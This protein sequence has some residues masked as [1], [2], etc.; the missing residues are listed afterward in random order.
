MD[1]QRR[2][3]LSRRLWSEPRSNADKRQKVLDWLEWAFA[4]VP[5]TLESMAELRASILLDRP[6]LLPGYIEVCQDD[7][8]VWETLSGLVRLYRG[9]ARERGE[10]LMLPPPLAKWGLDVASGSLVMPS[11]PARPRLNEYRD[12]HMAISVEKLHDLGCPYAP[13]SDNSACHL[14]AK[15][16]GMSLGRVR[17]IWFDQRKQVLAL[18]ATSAGDDLFSIEYGVPRPRPR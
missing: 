7:R 8:G 3:K 2:A 15:R 13:P 12:L 5:C 4:D 9:R 1:S 10:P 16:L 17:Q 6:D 11:W 14:I 18:K